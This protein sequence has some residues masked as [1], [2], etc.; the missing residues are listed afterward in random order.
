MPLIRYKTQDLGALD[1]TGTYLAKFIG[2][3]IRCFKLRSGQLFPPTHF[4][5]LFTRFPYLS[6]F[7]ITQTSESAFELVVEFQKDVEWTLDTMDNVRKYVEES[8]P[9]N[10]S[11]DIKHATFRR[12]G[13]FERFRIE[14]S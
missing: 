13:K 2:R 9:D 5:D 7:Q 6:E 14:M 12:D 3:K 4:N 8:I 1:E 11:V 10:P